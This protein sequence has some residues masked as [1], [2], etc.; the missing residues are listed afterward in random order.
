MNRL[1]SESHPQ[2]SVECDGEESQCQSS[3]S[4]TI[5][6][7]SEDMATVRKGVIL[8]G[9]RHSQG[10]PTRFGDEME[11]ARSLAP[12]GQS[13]AVGRGTG[14]GWQGSPLAEKCGD[15]SLS[16]RFGSRG[17]EV[18]RHAG[19]VLLPWPI[20]SFVPRHWK[21]RSTNSPN[22]VRP[23]LPWRPRCSR[24][25]VRILEIEIP[26]ILTHLRPQYPGWS[27]LCLAV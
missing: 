20:T 17:G 23:I 1:R 18:A 6:R 8:V 4:V 12:R 19:D 3:A 13:A 26:E 10:L 16:N 2:A 25:V 7:R 14:V 15:R 9:R 22:R 27:P 24:L 5:L 11:A 21:S